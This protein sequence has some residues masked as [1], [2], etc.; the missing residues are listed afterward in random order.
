MPGLTSLDFASCEALHRD[1]WAQPRFAGAGDWAALPANGVYRLF[2]SGEAAHG[3][4]RIV[5]IGAN[6]AGGGLAQRLKKHFTGTRRVSELRKLIGAALMRRDGTAEDDIYAWESGAGKFDWVEE[7][8]TAYLRSACS[9]AVTPVDGT[10]QT[11]TAV[12]AA[13]LTLLMNC[14][15]CVASDAWLG[16][17]ASLPGVAA[18]GLWNVLTG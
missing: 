3:G 6:L 12:Q 9:F 1:A 4:D 11:R 8:V 18:S 17:Y 5:C 2:E 16:H 13:W 7:W 14:R 10:P 15:E